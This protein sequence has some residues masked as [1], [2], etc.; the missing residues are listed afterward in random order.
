MR[1]YTAELS[2]PRPPVPKVT[3]TGAVVLDARTSSAPAAPVPPA[4]IPASQRA[5][6]KVQVVEH[7]LAQQALTILRNRQTSSRHF[8]QISNQ[9][10]A[11]L[12]IEATRALPSKSHPVDTAA[13]S[14]L[15]SVL[16]R[17]VI[18]LTLARHGLG[19][20]HN[21]ADMFPELFVGSISLERSA[22]TKAMGGRLHLVNAPAL[23]DAHVI[24]FDPVVSSGGTAQAALGLVQRCGA[25]RVTLISL[26]FSLPGLSHLQATFPDLQVWTAGIDPSLDAKRGPLPGLGNFAERLYG[27]NGRESFTAVPW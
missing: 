18:L 20:A 25:T 17:P 19:L 7:P 12:L 11:L 27:Y 4:P 9:L 3:T 13:G 6:A 14:H 1:S 15:G 16:A 21:M 26:L 23:A 5:A 10:L 8:R 24:L 2:N 22:E